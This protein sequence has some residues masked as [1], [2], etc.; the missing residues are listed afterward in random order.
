MAQAGRMDERITIEQAALV[1]DSAGQ[2]V[3][4]WTILRS[5]WAQVVAQTAHEVVISAQD[6]ALRDL[7][8][9]TRYQADVTALM[10]ISWR[11]LIYK[12]TGVASLRRENE[13]RIS[14]RWTDGG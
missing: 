2:P 5:V 10:R 13:T 6:T 12:I 14:A 1:Q 4:S 3:E 9:V 8:F 11:G 7:V